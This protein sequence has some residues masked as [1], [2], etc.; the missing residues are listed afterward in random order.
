MDVVFSVVV[1]CLLYYY[2]QACQKP[3]KVIP[4]KE[5]KAECFN[6]EDILEQCLQPDSEICQE[7]LNIGHTQFQ[8]S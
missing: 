2:G 6:Q 3:K 4:N 5:G 8:N 1:L 7:F